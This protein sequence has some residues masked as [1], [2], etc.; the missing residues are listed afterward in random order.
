MTD[1]FN[2]DD[3]VLEE[4]RFSSEDQMTRLFAASASSLN[5]NTLINYVASPLDLQLRFLCMAVQRF[6]K[7]HKDEEEKIKN[8]KS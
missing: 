5:L 4:R 1:N 8:V 6:S 3:L 7:Q 2:T